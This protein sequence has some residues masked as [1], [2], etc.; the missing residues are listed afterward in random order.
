MISETFVN[1]SNL[2]SHHAPSERG[3][4]WLGAFSIF[5]IVAVAALFAWAPEASAF[6][7]YSDC[8]G[9]HGAFT[10]P[11]SPTGSVFPSGSKHEMHRASGEM[12]TACLLCHT[13]IGDTPLMGSSGGTANNAGVGC[14]GCHG[15]EEDAGNDSESEGRGAGLRQHHT[16]ASVSSCS[17]CHSD[18][19]PANY[20]PVGENVM[21]QYYG[22]ADTNAAEACNL[23]ETPQTNENWT[24]GDFVGL[25]NNGDGLYDGDDTACGP[26]NSPPTA[27]AGPDQA[28]AAGATVNL[29]GSGSSDADGDPLTYSWT[30]TSVPSGSTAALSDPAVFNP[31]FVAD[32]AGDY[33]AQLVVNDGTADSAADSVTISASGANV[34][35]VADAGPD[36]AVAAG[37]IVNLDGSGSSDADGDTLTYSWSLT[38]VPSGSTAALSDPAAVM[39]TFVADMAGDYVAQLVVNDGMANS[40]PDT[41]MITANEPGLLDLDV[42]RFDVTKW[43][44]LGKRTKPIRIKVFVKNVSN[45]P[46]AGTAT[47]TGEQD[48]AVIY[49]ETLPVSV[50]TKKRGRTMVKFP[51]FTPTM[52]GNILWTVT[53]D[54]GDGILD[55]GDQDTAGTRVV[56]KIHHHDNDDKDNHKVSWGWWR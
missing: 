2:S 26:A 23:V 11:T 39:P 19:N 54:D 55:R 29:D 49:E 37:A 50:P 9:C 20:T 17:G 34:P 43:V 45:V 8:T 52:A 3:W 42:A 31:T 44:K 38:S 22:T 7:D 5:M 48:G 47:V 53:I 25:D 12:N 36:Q 56:G 21:P 14:V 13:S 41:V 32:M 24:V 33:V 16:N 51:S 1:S 15:R 30:L 40:D 35:P 18:A 4:K 46:G 27:D 10:G 28:V 6:E